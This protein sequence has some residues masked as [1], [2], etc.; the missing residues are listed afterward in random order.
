MHTAVATRR[1]RAQQ[2]E[3]QAEQQ[4]YTGEPEMNRVAEASPVA[5]YADAEKEKEQGCGSIRDHDC[6]VRGV[7]MCLNM[8]ARRP[9]S[10]DEMPG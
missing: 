3:Q 9:E 6:I 5:Q 4:A 8:A 1:G 2:T 7:T 10:S